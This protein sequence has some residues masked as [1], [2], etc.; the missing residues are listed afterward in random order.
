MAQNV[1]FTSQP[2]LPRPEVP[3]TSRVFR[4]LFSYRLRDPTYAIDVESLALSHTPPI[5][6]V[7]RGKSLENE[8]VKGANNK[9]MQRTGT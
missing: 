7:Q 1:P 5:N 4:L 8:G 2:P 3:S 9:N 6:D